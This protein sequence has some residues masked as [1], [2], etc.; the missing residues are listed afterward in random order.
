MS[1]GDDGKVVLEVGLN[2]LASKDQNPNV[3]YGPEE[4][5][6]D[7]VRC[8]SSGATLIHFHARYDD[9]RQAW[10]DAEVSRRALDA[11]TEQVDVIAYPSY[12]EGRLDHVFELAEHPGL[13]RLQVSPFDPVQH[14]TLVEWDEESRTFSAIRFHDEVESGPAYPSVLDELTRHN[15]APNMAAFNSGDLRWIVSAARAG[16]LRMPVNVK[17]FFSDRWVNNNDADVDVL[18]FL[19]SRIPSDVDHETVV[20]PYAMESVTR[21]E[22]LWRRALELGL[23]IRVGI[24]DNPRAFESE[25]NAELVEHAVSLCTEYGLEPATPQEFRVR[26]GLS[27]GSTG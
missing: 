3:P 1:L 17:L 27:A 9:G 21:A 10:L 24:G 5:A 18:D 20:I 13:H 6:A 16:Y 22:L 7:M 14:R 26:A 25:T 11:A 12:L 4:V 15:I 8:V 2:E 19:V 23:G